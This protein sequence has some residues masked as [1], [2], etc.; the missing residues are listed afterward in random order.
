[1]KPAY[2]ETA[3]FALSLDLES[4]KWN[5]SIWRMNSSNGSY[6]FKGKFALSEDQAKEFFKFCNY[7][8]FN[9]FLPEEAKKID[10][11]IEDLQSY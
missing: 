8:E 11:F 1:M 7:A 5:L 4:D 6:H 10:G 2:N 9:N 3:N